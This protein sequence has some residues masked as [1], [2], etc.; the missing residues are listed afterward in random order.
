MRKDRPRAATSL[1]GGGGRGRLLS[2]SAGAGACTLRRKRTFD[3]SGPSACCQSRC[4]SPT[5]GDLRSSSQEARES[6]PTIRS[7]EEPAAKHLTVHETGIQCGIVLDGR[8]FETRAREARLRRVR[9]A[10]VVALRRR[11]SGCEL[12]VLLGHCT[13]LAFVKRPLLSCFHA[14]HTHFS[15]DLLLLAMVAALAH[16]GVD[17]FLYGCGLAA[18]EWTRGDVAEAGRRSERSRYRL[19]AGNVPRTRSGANGFRR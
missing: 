6:H 9:S 2:S 4:F 5:E 14:S 13:Y 8:R 11:M 12:E 18:S 16:R 17:A 15:D 3:G 10:N 7:L 19:G 1:P